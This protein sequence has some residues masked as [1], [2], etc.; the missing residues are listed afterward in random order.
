MLI[1][2]PLLLLLLSLIFAAF[3]LRDYWR[4][5]RRLSS[6]ARTWLRIAFIFGVVALWLVVMV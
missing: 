4:N 2:T 5:A 3:S 1:S 6:A